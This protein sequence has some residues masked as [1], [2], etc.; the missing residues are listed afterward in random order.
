MHRNWKALLGSFALAAMTMSALTAPASAAFPDR[1]ISLIVPWAAG[2][3]TDSVAR[4]VA[5]RL[6][7]ELGQ[8][9]AVVN[10]TC[11]GG[12]VGHTAIAQAKPDGYTI[13]LITIEINM[14]H[15]VG[16]TDL[17][18]KGFT[19]FAL[20]NTDP[21]A[22]HVRSDSP[23]KTLKD[24]T[25]A[26]K[27]NPGKLKASGTSQG[28]GWH[29]ALAGLLRSLDVDPR[30]VPWVP[31]NGAATALTDLAAGGVDF[32]SCSLP[33]ADALMKAGRLRTL[34]F[35][36]AKRAAVAPDVPTVKEASGSD[37]TKGLWRGMV[38]P[39][40]LPADIAQKYEAALKRVYDSKEFQNFMRDRGFGPVWLNATDFAAFMEKDDKEIGDILKD[41]G[42]AK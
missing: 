7:Q 23:Y 42:L 21:A 8:P 35:M 1:P 6:E 29:L 15:W 39:K 37:W 27:A 22:I 20:I 30:T 25:D 31:V 24:L 19:P 14:M 33:E 28:G 3:G 17:T 18:Y 16:L 10:R 12:V 2:G 34:A 26:I 38:G 32:V 4:M 5:S 40:G 9:V 13:G 41:I 36:D 11:G